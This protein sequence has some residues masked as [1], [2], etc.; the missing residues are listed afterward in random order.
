MASLT[1]WVFVTDPH[2]EH[3][4]P[5]ASDAFFE[6]LDYWK[7]SVRIHG[8]DGIDL[9]SL[10]KGASPEDKAHG[11]SQDVYAHRQFM[12]RLQPHVWLR[13]NHDERLWDV[14]QNSQNGALRSMA[15]EL[16]ND[17]LDRYRD[18]QILP[19]C[20]RNG[21]Y[22]MGNYSFIHGYSH[23]MYAARQAVAAYGNVVMGHVHTPQLHTNARH[24]PERGYSCGCLC[25]LDLGYN[26]AH[27][28][29]LRQRHG[30]A[31]GVMTRAGKVKV[32]LAEEIDGQ[33]I[34]PS[35]V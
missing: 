24:E 19:Y 28:N 10:R 1:K 32:W 7:P 20:K 33:W 14:A 25:Q 6:F 23:G 34:F 15:G 4:D 22:K 8:G 18:V 13:G 11:I 16:V 5:T 12:E 30:W 35:E 3:I 27:L 17:M 26:R 9:A 21:V 2:G 31:Y 29:T